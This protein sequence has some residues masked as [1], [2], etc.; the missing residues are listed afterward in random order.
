MQKFAYVDPCGSPF[1]YGDL[2]LNNCIWGSLFVNG[3]CMH[4]VINRYISVRGNRL[5]A[6]C[7]RNMHI[8][9]AICIL[10]SHYAYCD[11]I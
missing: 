8:V 10:R 11:T 6:Y 9:V 7:G 3:V 1:A 5:Y 2:S 4:M